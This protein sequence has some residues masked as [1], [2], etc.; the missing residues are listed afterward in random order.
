M[1]ER[2]DIEAYTQIFEF[3]DG[4]TDEQLVAFG[5]SALAELKRMYK[6]EDENKPCD[7]EDP[8]YAYYWHDASGCFTVIHGAAECSECGKAWKA[9]QEGNWTI[10]F[11]RPTEDPCTD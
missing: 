11:D 7:C 9:T 3:D 6:R 1:E 4:I 5:L 10:H 8:D 2:I